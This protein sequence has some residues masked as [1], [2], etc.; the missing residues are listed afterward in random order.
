MPPHVHS[1]VHAPRIPPVVSLV[2]CNHWGQV[3]HILVCLPSMRLKYCNHPLHSSLALSLAVILCTNAVHSI[4]ALKPS[5]HALHSSL[6]LKPCTHAQPSLTGNAP[7]ARPQ[8]A[9]PDWQSQ[10][11]NACL[12][13]PNWQS[14][15]AMAPTGDAQL[16][17]PPT[18]NA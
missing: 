6:A 16:A 15:L 4:L 5:T 18:G 9:T 11:G 2:L 1:S 7:L 3:L 14:P 12:A 8:V 13:K 17:V 10:L